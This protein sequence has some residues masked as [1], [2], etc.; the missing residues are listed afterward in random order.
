MIEAVYPN[1]TSRNNFSGHSSP[2]VKQDVSS[3]NPEM[4]NIVDR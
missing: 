2:A 3:P 1:G 4:I